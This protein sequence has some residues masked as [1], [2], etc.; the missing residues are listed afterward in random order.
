M[1][2]FVISALLGL[3]SPALAQTALKP[4]L[5]P[6]GF[7]LGNWKSD[8]GKVAETGGTSKGGSMVSAQSD[9]WALLRQDHTELFDRN[10]KPA[11]GFHQT[12]VIYPD[13]GAVHA[14]YVDGE[15]HAIHY[16]SAEIAPNK[17]VTFS[18]APGQGPVFRLRYELQ[19]PGVMAVSFGMAPPG[20]S[21]FRP[22]AAGTLRKSQ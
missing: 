14:D 4:P 19:A 1:K 12:M 16:V 6:L 10:G 2:W 21:E 18:S 20:Q 13:D 9:G 8:D 15:G 3:T 22:I 17:S 7:L 11:G 5:A